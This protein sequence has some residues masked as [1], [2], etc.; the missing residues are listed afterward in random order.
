MIGGLAYLSAHFAVIK[1]GLDDPLDAVAV[2]AGG[3]KSIIIFKFV[4]YIN[5][6]SKE[7]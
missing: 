2:H 5:S 3:G 4:L 6:L 1:L 7:D